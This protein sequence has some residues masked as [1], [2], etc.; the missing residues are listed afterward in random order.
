VPGSVVWA[1]VLS[2]LVVLGGGALGSLAVARQPLWQ[3]YDPAQIS[4]R[5][6][7][8]G[9]VLA[10]TSV[11]WDSLHYLSIAQYGYRIPGDTVFFPVYPLLT[12]W[13]GAVTGS[14]VVAGI[15]I[16]VV[17]F[18]VG[19][20]LL[21][22]LTEL[23]L[24]RKAADAAVLLLAFA[25]LSFFF[26]AV[27]TESLF[28]ALSV[29]AVYAA[30][31]EHWTTAAL[32]A[33]V[34]AATRVPGIVVIVPVG[35][36]LIRSPKSSDWD[37]GLLALAPVA[38][39]SFLAYLHARGFGWLAPL[40]NQIGG[41]HLHEFTGSIATVADGAAAAVAGARA[42]FQGMPIFSPSLD[43]GPFSLG[44]ESIVLFIVFALALTAVVL[45]FRRLPVIYG[46]YSVLAL[47]VVTFSPVAGQPL[48][49]IDRYVLTIFPLWMAAGSWLVERRFLYL[50][51][52]LGA[53]L[54]FFYSFEFATWAFIA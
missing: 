37:F 38:L 11:R 45:C 39:F 29:G 26:T 30:R 20:T 28:L 25:P 2:R 48:R 40:K 13:L 18:I 6:G 46:I 14:E 8:V 44:F 7:A 35:W 5:L 51:L 54:L 47:I 16:S 31:R 3:L 27:Y 22:R 49:G 36:L 43:G 17:S 24:G 10:A 53:G 34:C 52:A 21:H 1:F 33:A 23:E 9:N 50:A 19:L 12:R 41:A 4:D 42:I 32:L 15:V